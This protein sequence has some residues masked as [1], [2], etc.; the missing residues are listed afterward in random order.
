MEQS[1]ISEN[2]NGQIFYLESVIAKPDFEL[3]STKVCQVAIQA[4]GLVFSGPLTNERE[5][6]IMTE[7]H[8]LAYNDIV[9]ADVDMKAEILV[10]HTFQKRDNNHCCGC[11]SNKKDRA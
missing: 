4:D 3:T 6:F 7:K 1:K 9:G 5:H 2:S 11:C 8:E 10:I